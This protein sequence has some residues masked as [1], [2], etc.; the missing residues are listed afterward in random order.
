MERSG[1]CLLLLL[2]WGWAAAADVHTV[3]WNSTNRR[4]WDDYTIQVQ[5][6]D[7]LDI[8]CPHYEDDRVAGTAVEKYTLF[9]VDHEEYVTCKP[10]SKNQVC[11]ECSNPFN[12]NGPEKFR[13]KFQK[14]T[15]FSRGKEFKEGHSYYYISKPVHHHGESCMKLKVQVVGKT[16]QQPATNVHNA[17]ARPVADDPTLA[18][19]DVLRSVAHNATSKVASVAL[20]ALLLPFLLALAL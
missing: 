1:C 2:H 18:L 4:F 19:P 12:L 7:Y 5:L 10:V 9:L 16:T 6:N 13:E 3:Y 8:V 14:F 15:A 11:W 20:F 17:G